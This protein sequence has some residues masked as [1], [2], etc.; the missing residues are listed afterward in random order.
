MAPGY[1]ERSVRMTVLVGKQNNLLG[2]ET[3]YIFSVKIPWD[4]L[5][6]VLQ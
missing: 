1:Q 4:Y 3:A 2:A 6:N 5:L